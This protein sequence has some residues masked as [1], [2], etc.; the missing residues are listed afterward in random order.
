MCTKIHVSQAMKPF[1]VELPDRLL[2]HLKMLQGDC[3]G[4]AIDRLEHCL[5][6]ATHAYRDGREVPITITYLQ[7]WPD[8]T[9]FIT[10]PLAPGTYRFAFERTVSR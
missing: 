2:T 8:D 10:V 7:R 3:G 6:T 4:F 5:Q 9:G 1:I